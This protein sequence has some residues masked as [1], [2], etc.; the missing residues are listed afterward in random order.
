FEDRRKMGALKTQDIPVELRTWWKLFQQASYRHDYAR[1]FDDFI[2][3]TLT[4]FGQHDRFVEWHRDAMKAY[5][6]KEKEAFNGMFF[7]L[8]NIFKD[9]TDVKGKEYYDMFGY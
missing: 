9:Q 8:F 3:M 7:E 2:T 4:Q 6:S 1:V 5:D